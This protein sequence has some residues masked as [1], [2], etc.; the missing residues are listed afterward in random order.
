MKT[1]LLLILAALGAQAYAA[2]EFRPEFVVVHSAEALKSVNVKWTKPVYNIPG[3]KRADG[4]TVHDVFQLGEVIELKQADIGKDGEAETWK[5]NHEAIELTA[6]RRGYRL[7]YH[8]TVKQPGTWSV[9]YAGAPAT[10]LTQVVELFQPLVWDGR[11]LPEASFLIPDDQCSIPGCLVQTSAGTVGVMAAPEQFP[12]VMPSALVRHFGVTLRNREGLAQPLVFTPFPGFA[13]SVM[14]AGDTRTFELELVSQEKPLS[15]TFEQVAREVCGFRDRREHTL[16]SLNTAL[17]SMLEYVLGPWGNFDPANKAFHYPDSP[18]SVK[19]VSA[20]HPIGLAR[21]TDNERLFREQGIPILEFLLSREKFL[22]ALNAEGMK[23]SQIPSRNLEGP[24]MPVSELAALQRIT[25]G[26]TPYFL[27]SAERLHGVDRALNMDWVTRGNSWQHD[28]WMYR[29]TGTKKWLESAKVKADIYIRE[30]VDTAPVDFKECGTNG[31]FFEYMLP[32]WK[33]LYELYEETHDPKHL[34]AAHRGARRYA[35]LIWFYP[36]VPEREITVN[37]SGFAPRRASLDKPGLLPVPMEK[38]PAWRVSE[39]GMTCE[40]N[41]TVQR[42]ALYLATHAPLFLR[43]AHDTDDAFL[44]E[45]ARSA[46][47]GRFA[48]FPGYHFN[49]LYSTAQE[50]ADFPLHPFEELKPTTS[51]HYNHVLPMA[52]LVLDYLIA[53]AYDRS[54][55]AIVF[56][57]EYAECYAFMQS[58]VFGEA[59]RFHDQNGVKPWMPQGLVK[60]DNVQVQ[61]IAAR[62]DNKVCVAL[63]NECARE[64]KDVNVTLNSACFEGGVDGIYQARWWRDNE[65]QTETVRVEKGQFK[66]SLSHHGITSMVIEGLKPKVAFQNKFNAVA[67]GP[68]A[69]T[70]QRMKTAAGEIQAMVLSFG[71]EMTWVYAYLTAHEEAVKSA[72]MKVVLP[73][74]KEE[75]S[76]ESFPFEFSLPLRAGEK[77]VDL[78][79]ESVSPS[80]QSHASEV[81]RLER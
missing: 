12:F 15:E 77:T 42:L 49:T 57:S 70:H 56:P 80:G 51:F 79:F 26:G 55:G 7:R 58:R 27:S 53:E 44:R 21:M 11:R 23:S 45:I 30:R 9:A 35:Q 24:A 36:F 33:D 72:R 40:G 71:D 46:M 13:D 43:I 10:P 60:A 2:S 31:T 76:D 29:A 28:L 66:V 1:V 32:A 37:Q 16:A 81:M 8:Y 50:K 64:L 67:S 17:D 22:F 3:W 48:N 14:K 20:L 73:E 61:Y 4:S 34:A 18:G 75:M 65:L 6:T 39:H 69:V 59:G 25:H 47:I 54:K 38:V 78:Q 5:F 62:G 52:N 74:R 68:K 41:G 19:N 63:M